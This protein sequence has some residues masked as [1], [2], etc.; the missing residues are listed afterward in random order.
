MTFPL[1]LTR[2]VWVGVLQ[3]DEYD[4]SI[5]VHDEVDWQVSALNEG[6]LDGALPGEPLVD[7]EL[8]RYA[9]AMGLARTAL[10][11]TV[12]RIRWLDFPVP[13]AL[14]VS[15]AAEHSS[16]TARSIYSTK[17]LMGRGRQDRQA[18]LVQWGREWSGFGGFIVDV[19]LYSNSEE[20]EALRVRLPNAHSVPWPEP[21]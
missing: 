4:E 19:V 14:D 17:E 5:S 16:P 15:R 20:L 18:L 8:D 7:F 13:A 21:E 1:K 6:F 10:T 2:S 3:L 11:G 9:E 12:A